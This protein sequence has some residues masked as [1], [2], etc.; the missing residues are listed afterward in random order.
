[1]NTATSNPASKGNGVSA[2][3]QTRQ[4]F[5][6]APAVMRGSELQPKILS[7]EQASHPGLAS[8]G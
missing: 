4:N 1:M 3:A 5:V 7:I 2:P 6:D 8:D